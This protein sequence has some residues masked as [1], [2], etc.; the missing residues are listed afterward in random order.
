MSKLAACASG[1]IIVPVTLS[2]R[3]E[4]HATLLRHRAEVEVADESL[5]LSVKELE[6][7]IQLFN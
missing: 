1:T 7:G 6:H 3:V 2:E 4:T 5:L